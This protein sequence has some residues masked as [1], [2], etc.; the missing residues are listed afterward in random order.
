MAKGLKWTEEENVILA[1]NY[2]DKGKEELSVLL[3]SRTYK[4][5]ICQASLLGL[6]KPTRS[7]DEEELTILQDYYPIS[8]PQEIAAL[9]PK[10]NNQTITHM[11][12]KLGIYRDDHFWSEQ[13]DDLLRQHYDNMKVKDL[14]KLFPN[15]TNNGIKLRA[16]MLGL[17][18]DKSLARRE[19]FYKYDFFSTPNLI[20]SYYAGLIAADGSVSEINKHLRVSL[21]DNDAYILEKFR[22]DIEYTGD[23]KYFNDTPGA[24]SVVK[25][26]TKVTPT[27]LL[28]ISGAG[29][30]I[31]DLETNYSIVPN[32]TLILQ[33]PKNLKLKNKLAFIVGLIDGDG[34]VSLR[35][36]ERKRRRDYY[37]LVISLA[38]T[39]DILVWV[40]EVF[41]NLKSRNN[42]YNSE[43]L[44]QKDSNIWVYRVGG[45]RAYQ[46][47]K[48]LQSIKTPTRLARKWSK[49]KEYEELT[50]NKC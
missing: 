19:Y 42:G 15:R 24:N 10:R 2:G 50:G 25:D 16:R 8:S 30:A 9:L 20:N 11:A 28:S 45:N 18:Q 14:L 3:P 36:T 32:K 35:T 6:K 43:V 46:I 27:A 39:F 48:V 31:K 5:I 34:S 26:K 1:D 41:D 17:W 4:S 40:K 21:K 38:G 23:I 44:K 13:E 29:Q 7:W 47:L 37:D 33:P 22:K 49:I 12:N